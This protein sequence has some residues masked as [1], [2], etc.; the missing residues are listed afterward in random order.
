MPAKECDYI[1][2][3]GSGGCT[4]SK[5]QS[6]HILRYVRKSRRNSE[7]ILHQVLLTKS[8]SPKKTTSPEHD[9]EVTKLEEELFND[10]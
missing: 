6:T 1:L 7:Q 5:L 2:S 9:D 4:I 3:I 10:F 8:P